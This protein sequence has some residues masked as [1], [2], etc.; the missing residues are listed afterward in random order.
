MTTRTL[1]F[2]AV[3]VLCA[4]TL[5]CGQSAETADAVP[6]VLV[7][8][9]SI[10]AQVVRE[11]LTVFGTITPDPLS[12]S[13]ITA[14][15]AVVMAQLSVRLGQRVATGDPI[16]T[17]ES[18]PGAA[19]AFQ[20]SASALTFAKTDLDR[21]RRLY[22]QRLATTD[23]LAAAQHALADANAAAI[24]Q[25]KLHGAQAREIIRAPFDGIITALSVAP[26]DKV[27][28]DGPIAVVA[29]GGGLIVP[30]GL[31]PTDAAR[32]TKGQSV[33]I[34][35]VFA[36]PVVAKATIASVH[37]MV[38]PATRLVDA[39]A[40]IDP[41]ASAKFIIGASVRAS[42]E[43][44]SHQALVVPRDA[45]LTDAEGSYLF[46]IVGGKAHLVRV[47]AGTEQGDAAEISGAGIKAGDAVVSLGN[48]ELADG[49]PVRLSAK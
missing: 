34:V 48:Y 23:Q 6:S 46:V 40:S 36:S 19:L 9:T 44:A 20:Q 35:P 31:E 5:G 18:A 27:A 10:R 8:T 28:A 47:K 24:E 1:S 12:L 17:F 7:E 41:E 26:G 37:G 11:T 32:V 16:A 45:V 29:R 15:R 21:V 43:I 38:N 39:V 33:V 2:I 25:S 3:A 49:T 42:I 30:L 13:T 4:A 14:P 22:A